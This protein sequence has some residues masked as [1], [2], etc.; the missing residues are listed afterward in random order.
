[1]ADQPAA[2]A[3]ADLGDRIEK[4]LLANTA[5][6]PL[7][8]GELARCEGVHAVRGWRIDIDIAGAAVALDLTIDRRFPRSRP[9]IA[10]ADPPPFPSYPHVEEDGGI[11]AIEQTDELDPGRPIGIIKA[12]LGGAADVLEKGFSGAN[13]ED[14]RTEFLSYWNPTAS[15][16]AVHSLLDPCGDTRRIKVWLGR[17]G[18][19]V[20]E[21]RAALVAWL[22][23]RHGLK[24]GPDQACQPGLL[25]WL[26]R[27]LLPSE[28]PRTPEDLRALAENVGGSVPDMFEA[29]LGVDQPRWL[30][31]LGAPV[32]AGACF[33]AVLIERKRGHGWTAGR[34][35]RGFRKGNMPAN[36]VRAEALSGTLARREVRRVD[37]RWIHG[38]DANT[39]LDVLLAAQVTIVG[40]GSLGA[41]VARLLAQAGVGA[42]DLIDPEVL[43]AAN[44]A[45]HVLGSGEVGQRKAAAL[46]LRLQRDFP[47]LRITDHSD[48]WQAVA[49]REPTL[50]AKADL[51]ISTIGSWSQE[52]ELNQ[53]HLDQGVPRTSLYAWAE[54]HAVGGHAVLIGPNGGCLACGLAPDGRSL[55]RVAEFPGATLVREPACG[56]YFQPYG[57]AEITLVASMAAM[58]ALDHLLGQAP[59]GTYRV[60]STL[61][62]TLAAAGGTWS[63]QW[64][65]AT[66]GRSS[67]AMVERVWQHDLACP[68]CRDKE[69]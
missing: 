42:I 21:D 40:C 31:L 26:P 49:A 52:G 68:A 8:E 58:L 55:F 37:P 19:Y 45:R 12:A 16:D 25:L 50:L 32:E 61:E 2:G 53:H 69:R 11:C 63:K 62:E 5:A 28:Y 38:R 15:G 7:S 60:A 64:R 43:V 23:N 48:C 39:D 41:P 27:P 54:P 22:A 3:S 51:A 66:A 14:F 44:T 20:A 4:W 59:S 10:L 36:M 30:V 65:R 18:H 46:A 56:G 33:A 29:L 67:G 9:N 47:H 17:S 57:A 35:K 6:R 13:L 1:M 34:R 24:L